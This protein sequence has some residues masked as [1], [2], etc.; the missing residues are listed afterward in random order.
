MKKFITSIQIDES[1]LTTINQSRNYTIKGDSGSVFYI[2]VQTSDNRWYNFST[3]SFDSAGVYGPNNRLDDVEIVGSSYTGSITFPSDTDGE[4]YTFF[5]RPSA[6]FNTELANNLVSKSLNSDG[7]LVERDY[8]KYLYTTVIQQKA[9]VTVTVRLKS[10]DNANSYTTATTTQGITLT[11]SPRAT[12]PV[13][14]TFDFTIENT[15]SDANG[16]GLSKVK[17][18]TADD[19]FTLPTGRVNDS[20]RDGSTSHFNY[21]LD[22]INNVGVGMGIQTTSPGSVTGVPRV[23]KARRYPGNSTQAGQPFVKFTVAQSLA[24]NTLIT[25][26]AND[27]QQIKNGSNMDIAF[28]DLKFEI[29]EPTTT[30]V[31]GAISSSTSVTVS[32]TYGFGKSA[33]DALEKSYIE[34][35]SVDNTTD[36]PIHEIT[37]S[38]SDGTIITTPA[39]TLADDTVLTLVNMAKKW[40]VSGRVVVKQFPSSDTL[41]YL[42]LDT[43]LV[44]GTGS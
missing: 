27:S 32:G 38:S 5:L 13:T 41:V 17:D 1:D 18:L 37:A 30:L 12:T 42:N 2:Q 8:N 7:D 9:N 29:K 20:S 43:I 4:T 15:S 35:L 3:K 14:E 11:A 26:R 34:G 40:K 6:H 24:D 22:D 21:V 44:P 31:R 25:F 23:I 39:Q 19:F 36:N 16:F 33:S 28:E 10:G